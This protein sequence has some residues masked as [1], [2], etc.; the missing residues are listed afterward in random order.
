MARYKA[1]LLDSRLV[2]A[3]HATATHEGISLHLLCCPRN[4]QAALFHREQT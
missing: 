1:F 4:S 2:S 3:T